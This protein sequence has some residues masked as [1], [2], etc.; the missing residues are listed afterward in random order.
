MLVVLFRKHKM[1]MM[2]LIYVILVG[3]QL[4][5][6]VH[7][8]SAQ[9]V[10]D[11]SV[12]E[13]TIRVDPK[14]QDGFTTI[15]AAFDFLG[16]NPE[17]PI[18]VVIAP[19]TYREG[20]I[21]LYDRSAVT[22]IEGEA[23][24]KVVISGSDI[25]KD[26]KDEGEGKFS[27]SWEYDWGEA[28]YDDNYK[29]RNDLGRRS[30]LVFFNGKK[31]KQVESV[32]ALIAGSY[33]V[34]EQGDKLWLMPPSGSSPNEAT[35][36]VGVRS[37]LIRCHNID[38]F[39]FRNLTVQHAVNS[40]VHGDKRFNFAV[41]G[42]EDSKTNDT[43]DN[44]PGRNLCENILIE[45]CTFQWN[46]NSGMIIANSRYVTFR[47]V[48][49]VDN[50][51]AGASITRIADYLIDDCDFNRNNWRVGGYGGYTGWAPAGTKIL[52]SRQGK[53]QNS[54]F[55]DN[56]ATGLWMDFGHEFIDIVGCT[57]SGNAE[58]G[59]YLEASVGPFYVEE[60]VIT[61][62]GATSSEG[63][64]GGV[65]VAEAM[66]ITIKNCLIAD[67]NYYQI[68]IRTRDRA[69][70]SGYW[71]TSIFDGKVRYLTVEDC[72]LIGKTVHQKNEPSF[73]NEKVDHRSGG[74]IM[75]HTHG[76]SIDGNG[77]Y[78]PDFFL[79]TYVGRGNTF[80]HPDRTEVFSNGK[81][82]GFK[83]VD[84]ETWQGLTN[85]DKDSKWEKVTAKDWKQ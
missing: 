33:A 69:E 79:P 24:G 73:Y 48:N 16:K 8:A 20:E 46:N 47:K 25:W 13:K 74:L 39:V 19:G 72:V 5:F 66:H 70:S 83:R 27:K 2:K 44:Y 4:A 82:Y 1:I 21:R 65:L 22:V 23:P 59:L 37:E 3:G 81:S 62:N 35:V 34:D 41:F 57:M 9:A 6:L 68:G 61:N 85:Q 18:K 36:E 7:S 55:L 10:V 31:L 63:F 32:D 49:F 14:S 30:E 77:T 45:N 11:E 42:E 78:Y 67:N 28:K 50:G 40:S 60:C 15:K 51:N 84:L 64:S 43:I 75:M 76:E 56:L 58:E 29:I 71:G 54:R 26:W 38:N 17:L 53:I 52:F 80:Y 12:I